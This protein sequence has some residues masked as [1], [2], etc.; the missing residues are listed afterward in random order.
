MKKIL[1]VIF[2]IFVNIPVV[3]GY[4]EHDTYTYYFKSDETPTVQWDVVEGINIKYDLYLKRFEWNEIVTRI[5]NIIVLEQE[6]I[7]PKSGMY[8]IQVRARQDLTE[9]QITTINAMTTK[10]QLIP[11]VVEYKLEDD[12]DTDTATVEEIKTVLITLGMASDWTISDVDD[13]GAVVTGE[14]IGWWCYSYIAAPG[15]II[16]TG[17][18]PDDTHL[19]EPSIIIGGEDTG[20]DGP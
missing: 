6:L 13:A 2:L 20:Q 14:P 15:P 1:F 17:E 18:N 16:I 10:E 11:K 8:I 5:I 9:S 7:F 19:V 12:V 3:Y 4:S